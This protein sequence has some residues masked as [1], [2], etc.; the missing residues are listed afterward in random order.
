MTGR[1]PLFG[2]VLRLLSER[3]IGMESAD[4]RVSLPTSQNVA[5]LTV[6]SVIWQSDDGLRKSITQVIFPGPM[7]I[8]LPALSSVKNLDFGVS[9]DVHVPTDQ[10]VLPAVN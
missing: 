7:N 8:S 1:R 6:V 4:Q 2:Q 10:H 9:G 5:L 3:Q